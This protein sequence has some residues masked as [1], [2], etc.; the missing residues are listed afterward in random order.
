MKRVKLG[1]DGIMV[2]GCIHSTGVGFFEGRLNGNAYTLI[3][4]GTIS[5]LSYKYSYYY[6]SCSYIIHHVQWQV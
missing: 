5:A 2:W 3:C 1:G 6:N 4:L